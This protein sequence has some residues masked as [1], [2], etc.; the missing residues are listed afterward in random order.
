VSAAW[1]YLESAGAGPWRR[2]TANVETAQLGLQP[3]PHTCEI[4]L[5]SR[6][7]A[8][9]AA[10][11]L[12]RLAPLRYRIVEVAYHEEHPETEVSDGR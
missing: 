7:E 12:R 10:E 11:A 8:E 2:V 6:V 3:D 9:A 5:P 1:F 4:R